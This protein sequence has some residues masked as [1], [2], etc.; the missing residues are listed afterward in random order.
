MAFRV[1]SISTLGAAW[2]A[3]ASGPAAL[4][5]SGDTNGAYVGV[6]LISLNARR[7]N[8]T[9][10]GQTSTLTT[11]LYPA[12]SASARIGGGAFK[13]APAFVFTPLPRNTSDG[14]KSRLFALAAP[15]S[16]EIG[17][18]DVR[19]GPG[20]LWYAVFA[21]GGTK[22]LPNGTSTKEFALPDRT[23]VSRLYVL[24]AGTGMQAGKFRL[25]LDAWATEVFSSRRSV[26]IA[27]N[28][29]YGV[30]E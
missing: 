18:W 25:E 11:L 17:R 22:E 20:V 24:E 7:F 5:A 8:A 14:T 30:Y 15:V 23:A 10:A 16:Y 28:V 19:A 6:G 26:S 13:L 21:N 2:L 4:A 3:L 1:P 27:F 29:V 9:S 12:L